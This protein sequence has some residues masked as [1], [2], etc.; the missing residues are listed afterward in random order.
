MARL[1]V[2]GVAWVLT[3]ALATACLGG[4]TGEPASGRSC[5]SRQLSPDDSWE[6]SRVATAAGSFAGTYETSL[7]WQAE[8]A[9]G[10]LTPVDFNDELQLTLAYEDDSAIVQACGEELVVPLALTLMTS[11]SGLAESGT[12]QLVLR[13]SGSG[14]SGALRFEGERVALEATLV[15]GSAGVVLSGTL[16]A[17]DT[18]LPGSSA[19]FGEEP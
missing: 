17:F 12:A 19:T 2:R 6:G 4:Q 13:S 16:D 3:V 10:A 14:L 9:A 15:E 8:A 5:R 1:K 18:E 7:S 11:G